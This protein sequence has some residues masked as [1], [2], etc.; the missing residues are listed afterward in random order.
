MIDFLISNKNFVIYLTL[1]FIFLII[2]LFQNQKTD[3]IRKNGIATKG[4]IISYS[5]EKSYSTDRTTTYYYPVIK[6]TDS[7]G[8]ARQIKHSIGTSLKPYR[9]L[10][11]SLK[12]YYIENDGKIDIITDSK[13]DDIIPMG[14][15]IIGI[16]I[17]ITN[18]FLYFYSI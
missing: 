11:Y 6:F 17:V 18:L 9:N 5:P 4:E 3:S 2:G 13:L 10:P 15:I 12:I 7:K 16:C 14:F 1:G 8:V